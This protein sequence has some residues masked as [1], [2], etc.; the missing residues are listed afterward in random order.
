MKKLLIL[1]LVS[2]CLF[3]DLAKAAQVFPSTTSA[4]NSNTL[5]AEKI[6]EKVTKKVSDIKS[7]AI[8]SQSVTTQKSTTV[9]KIRSVNRPQAVRSQ[10]DTFMKIAYTAYKKKDYNTALINFN[11]ALT[12]RPNDK[13]ATMGIQNAQQRLAGK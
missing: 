2:S 9:T 12:S 8:N 6:T 10:Y 4:E 7:R 1:T 5:I 11:R 13:Y 3:G